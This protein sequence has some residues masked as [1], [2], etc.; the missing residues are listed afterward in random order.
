MRT[1]ALPLPVAMP[2]LVA[3]AVLATGCGGEP[4]PDA[5]GSFEATEV[6]VSTRA[7]GQLER[8]TA[9]EGMPLPA[10]AVVA[11]VDTT[12]LALE[13]RQ[14]SAQRGAAGAR[15]VE[16]SRQLAVLQV[17]RDIARRAYERT[18]RLHEQRAATAPQLD[19]AERDYRT[20]LAQIEALR[21]QGN[22][23][24]MD[25]LSTEARVAQIRERI[26]ESSVVNPRA[27]TVLTTYARVGEVVQPGQPLYRIADLDTLVLRAYVTGDQL[28]S[29]RLGQRVLV[30]AEQGA[31]RLLAT[32]GTVSWISPTAEFTPT[33]IQT[34]DERADLVYAV[35]VRVP[36]PDGALKIGMPGDVTFRA[37]GEEES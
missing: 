29:V 18:R 15:T 37:G 16:V 14:L 13:E 3:S 7:G 33:P 25:A 23:V 32:A 12:Q 9:V 22:T 2:V 17:Q 31:D 1:I 35:K 19:Q 36:N 4:E 21:A 30:Q 6:V 28:A 26:T 5:Y 24:G 10:G 11:L 27:G 8:F 34:R 20:L